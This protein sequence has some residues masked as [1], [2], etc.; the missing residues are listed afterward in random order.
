MSCRGLF[1][2]LFVRLVVVVACSIVISVLNARLVDGVRE[3]VVGEPEEQSNLNL[4]LINANAA[5]EVNVNLNVTLPLI[6][7]DDV[8]SGSRGPIVTERTSR[9][10]G[11]YDSSAVRN[12]NV[13][14]N[15]G[16]AVEELEEMLTFA[17][18]VAANPKFDVDDWLPVLSRRTV[19]VA[20][21]GTQ[22]EDLLAKRAYG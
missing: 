8:D 11:L 15:V 14:V 13:N 4:K 9:E 3:G 5:A 18:N 2:F 7:R 12:I 20:R 21:T 22:A 10:V 19:V 16:R 6:S 17:Q 1:G